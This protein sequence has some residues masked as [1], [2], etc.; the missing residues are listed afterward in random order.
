MPYPEKLKINDSS[1]ESGFEK[2]KDFWS[3]KTGDKIEHK[4]WGSG[5]ILRVKKSSDDLEL[6]VA[7][8]SVGLKNTY[9]HCTNKEMYKI[10]SPSHAEVHL[11]KELIMKIIKLC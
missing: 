3:H 5:E 1:G 9:K 7:F 11:M 6:D 2:E 10:N 8:R 4:L